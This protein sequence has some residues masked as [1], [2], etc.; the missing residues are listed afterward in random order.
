MKKILNFISKTSSGMALGLFATLI[1]GTLLKQIFSLIPDFQV[2]ID[3]ATIGF[4]INVLLQSL[5]T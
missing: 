5:K 2:G 4:S 1:V 3:I